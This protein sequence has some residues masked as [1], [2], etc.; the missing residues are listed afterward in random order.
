MSAVR[1]LLALVALMVA[2]LVSFAVPEAPVPTTPVPLPFVAHEPAIPEREVLDPD[3]LA[4]P[5]SASARQLPEDWPRFDPVNA[6]GSLDETQAMLTGELDL[7]LEGSAA[8]EICDDPKPSASAVDE[9]EQQPEIAEAR[10]LR[11]EARRRREAEEEEEQRRSLEEFGLTDE[12]RAAREEQRR[13]E[14][15]EFERLITEIDEEVDKG[16][17]PFAAPPP[18]PE[19]DPD[20][21]GPVPT[22]TPDPESQPPD[23]PQPGYRLTTPDGKPLERVVV[24]QSINVELRVTPEEASIPGRLGGT[25]ELEFIEVTL[26]SEGGEEQTIRLWRAEQ[27]SPDGLIRFVSKEPVS[28]AARVNGN[29]LPGTIEGLDLDLRGEEGSPDQLS[30]TIRI[31]SGQNVQGGFTT[32]VLYGKQITAAIAEVMHAIDVVEE[33]LQIERR[34]V[35]ELIEDA[36]GDEEVLADLRGW[37][38]RIDDQLVVLGEARQLA[39]YEYNEE[40]KLVLSST[41][42]QTV[43][44][45]GANGWEISEANPLRTGMGGIRGT[46]DILFAERKRLDEKYKGRAMVQRAAFD[47]IEQYLSTSYSLFSHIT[48]GAPAFTLITGLDE[49]GKQGSR[50]WAL[51]EIGSGVAL[52]VVA[53]KL[54][55]SVASYIDEG[56]LLPSKNLEYLSTPRQGG[57]PGRLGETRVYEGT[58]QRPVRSLPGEAPRAPRTPG[59]GGQG[60][61]VVD[62]D[63]NVRYGAGVE[64]AGGRLTPGR[65]GLDAEDVRMWRQRES[66]R[67]PREINETN[68]LISGMDEAVANARQRGVPDDVIDGVLAEARRVDPET[69]LPAYRLEPAEGFVSSRLEWEIA[70]RNRERILVSADERRQLVFNST[71]PEAAATPEHLARVEVVDVV[72]L[73]SVITKSRLEAEGKPQIWTPEE[74]RYGRTIER[75]LEAGE[76]LASAKTLTDLGE[77]VY[78]PGLRPV[79]GP[80]DLTAVRTTFDGRPLRIAPEAPAQPRG[81]AGPREPTQ[82]R[83][84]AG[85]RRADPDADDAPTVDPAA[86]TER[87]DSAEAP[88]IEPSEL[89]TQPPTER[90]G[91]ADRAAALED[92][93]PTQRLDPT[94]R[95]V[96]PDAPT[97]RIDPTERFV[98]P[99]APTERIE[100]RALTERLDPP[101][102]PAA[103]AAR[104][105]DVRPLASA[106]EYQALVARQS[107]GQP[108]DLGDVARPGIARVTDEGI[109]VA[110]GA[111][112][113]EQARPDDWLDVFVPGNAKLPEGI[114]IVVLETNVPVEVV[115]QANLL[116]SRGRSGSNPDGVEIAVRHGGPQGAEIPQWTRVRVRARDTDAPTSVVRGQIELQL[117]NLRSQGVNTSALE[118]AIAPLPPADRLRVIE[119]PAAR[120]RAI[121][122][123]VAIPPRQPAEFI[124]DDPAGFLR[125]VYGNDA[126]SARAYEIA[127]RELGPENVHGVAGS[128]AQG[129]PRVR[130]WPDD[131]GY[132]DARTLD[133]LTTDIPPSVLESLPPRVQELH[134]RLRELGG[135]D[136]LPSDL[137]VAVG[138]SVERKTLAAVGAKIFEETGVL[139]EFT[140]GARSVPPRASAAVETPTPAVVDPALDPTAVG[141]PSGRAGAA[142]RLEPLTP[143]GGW[144][145]DLDTPVKDASSSIEILIQSRG[146]ST[147]PVLE[148]LSLNYGQPV[149]LRTGELILEP[150]DDL[151]AETRIRIEQIRAGARAGA[152]SL[153]LEGFCLQLQ[154]AVPEAG[155]VY[156][157]ADRAVQQSGTPVG[158][159]LD[160]GRLLQDLGGLH[161]DTDPEDYFHSIRQWA[162]WVHEEGLDRGAFEAEF[163]EHVRRTFEAADHE[164]NSDVERRLNEF[165]PN[166]W[167]DVA[168]I[169]Q[170]AGRP[171]PE[172]AQ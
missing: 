93:N 136:G 4:P 90:M 96:D 135:G 75:R 10:R 100:G 7:V 94:E 150:I 156:R 66:P 20:D 88:T 67:N 25:R 54:P 137:D 47:T 48:L 33:Q 112:R 77:D 80:D 166:R 111:G 9:F 41:L 87:I 79:F 27:P 59:A 14:E 1:F 52:T 101:G 123:G 81:P 97:E 160:A 85:P 122:T 144:R 44:V 107:A 71:L 165:I 106:E 62:G 26:I 89:P 53:I 3:R 35:L 131:I 8:S 84:P 125:S 171:V 104:P 149:V 118:Q 55:G 65:R 140:P 121:E 30:E 108:V 46:G 13:R 109:Q 78:G 23:P 169:L 130:S 5:V 127:I 38:Q 167:N 74:V 138:R 148:L 76:D 98:D 145:E 43:I 147:G 86:P 153:V 113:W 21:P 12:E 102:E 57:K 157:I 158:A 151:D 69:G 2:A 124:A 152:P 64:S 143:G 172:T 120:A 58:P 132:V 139:V 82:P 60:R 168:A 162:I 31:R 161:P 141:G 63:G 56:R 83:E 32:F 34:F 105:A 115:R 103:G 70:T 15:E 92:A 128:Y 117:D 91:P 42:L 133:K 170:V 17:G 28:I 61:T 22:T 129:S 18:V 163:V 159:I 49:F 164:W 40:Y 45:P 99:D 37:L 24:G 39:E 6:G 51:V 16:C 154:R 146:G 68:E 134:A 72:R 73:E 119:N 95:L 29:L 116:S 142:P 36:A 11:E 114:D 19:P 50:V 155:T 126:A 110:Q